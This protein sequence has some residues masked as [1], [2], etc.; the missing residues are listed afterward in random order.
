[1]VVYDEAQELLQLEFRS[2]AVGLY[3]EVAAAMH[4]ALLDLPAKTSCKQ[5]GEPNGTHPGAV[6]GR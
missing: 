6:A 1:M 3:V 5:S 4:P 2:W